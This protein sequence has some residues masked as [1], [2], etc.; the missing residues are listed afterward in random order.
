MRGMF[1]SLACSP[2]SARPVV[3]V[4]ALLCGGVAAVAPAR[5]GAITVGSPGTVT[6]TH[7]TAA[8]APLPGGASSGGL[9]SVTCPSAS[10]CVAVGDDI[11]TGSGSSWSAVKIPMPA[12]APSTAS[13]HLFS[14][15][16]RSAIRCVAVGYYQRKPSSQS[17]FGLIVTGHGST[18]KAIKA[19]LPANA[20][21]G[22]PHPGNGY[23]VALNSVACYAASSCLAA[24]YYT[25]TSG[26][27][28]G[29]LVTKSGSSWTAAE[30]P[31]PP[32]A[33]QYQEFTGLYSAACPAASLC[34][35]AGQYDNNSTAGAGDLLET[36]FGSSWTVAKGP[37]GGAFGVSCPSATGCVAV[38]GAIDTGLGSQWTSA[39]IPPPPGKAAPYRE[40]SAVGCPSVS[41]CTAV[42]YYQTSGQPGLITTWSGSSWA[43]VTAPVPTGAAKPHYI[44]FNG[45]SCPR[46]TACAAVGIYPDSQDYGQGVIETGS[47]STWTAATAPLP[48]NDLPV[49]FETQG[50]IG[51]PQLSAIACPTQSACVAVGSYVDTSDT[52]QGMLLTGPA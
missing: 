36:G 3:A 20:T 45:I 50:S 37:G 16:C 18:W 35:A 43:S 11:V 19:R 48:A 33:S 29:L 26:N 6:A 40:L 25:D 13:G 24:G 10:V 47:A 7:W 14:V 51:P 28:E 34:V 5:A 21:T 38:G 42:G 1:R 46:A 2:R 4:V 8:E 22:N 27:F 9:S 30:A 39:T 41:S 49:G 23:P 31:L 15:T 12:G 17:D 44:Q 52:W 32:D